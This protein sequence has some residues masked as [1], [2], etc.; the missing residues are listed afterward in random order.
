MLFMFAFSLSLSFSRI[1]IMIIFFYLL[2]LFAHL[3]IHDILLG[4]VNDMKRF[5]SYRVLLFALPCSQ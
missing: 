4:L 3:F 1:I 2:L 5:S